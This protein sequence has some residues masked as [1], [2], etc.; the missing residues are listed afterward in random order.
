MYRADL[1]DDIIFA[2]CLI[3]LMVTLA[4]A[5][6]STSQQARMNVMGEELITPI[7]EPTYGP[8]IEQCQAAIYERITEGCAD[9]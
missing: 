2:G 1:I 9:A 8:K 3:A 6:I 7:E 4:I 5:V